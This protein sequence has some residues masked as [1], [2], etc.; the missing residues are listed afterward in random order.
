MNDKKIRPLTDKVQVSGP[1]VIRYDIDI[2]YYINK[3]DIDKAVTI[4]KN[5]NQAIEKYISWQKGMIGR[6][7]NPSNL[8][9]LIIQAGAKRVEIN[10]PERKVLSNTQIGLINNKNVIYGGLEDD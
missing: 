6:D 2:K 9:A 7:I 3:S 1:D 10:S 4:Q 5:V 8:I